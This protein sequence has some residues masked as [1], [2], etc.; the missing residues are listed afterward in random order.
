[1]Y[2]HTYV[3]TY[4]PMYTYYVYVTS[5]TYTYEYVCK[6]IVCSIAAWWRRCFEPL[7][8]HDYHHPHL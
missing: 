3:H 5:Y 8:E 2:I 6:L 1:M 4:I 7:P